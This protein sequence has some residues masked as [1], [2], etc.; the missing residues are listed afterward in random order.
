VK[1]QK[2]KKK[3]NQEGERIGNKSKEKWKRTAPPPPFN[4]H[5]LTPMFQGNGMASAFNPL[6][7]IKHKNT[8]LNR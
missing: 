2:K 6:F 5:Y 4:F 8:K 3:K 1:N 7:L